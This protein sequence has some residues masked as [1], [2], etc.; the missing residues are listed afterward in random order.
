MVL[1][2]RR[3][4]GQWSHLDFGSTQRGKPWQGNGALIVGLSSGE[5]E[6]PSDAPDQA[7]AGGAGDGTAQRAGGGPD[8][9]PGGRGLRGSPGRQSDDRSHPGSERVEGEQRA[10]LQPAGR[11]LRE[12]AGG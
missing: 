10:V 11:R 8:R 7:G 9:R 6:A 2:Y 12:T 5:R 4:R 3:D 1:K